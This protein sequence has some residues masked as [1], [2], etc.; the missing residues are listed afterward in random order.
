MA[1]INRLKL[2]PI[3]L[4]LLINLFVRKTE[5]LNEFGKIR[6]SRSKLCFD[7]IETQDDQV[8]FIDKEYA[9]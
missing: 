7:H 8:A 5:L 2:I 6:R 4:F 3:E 1:F 9:K